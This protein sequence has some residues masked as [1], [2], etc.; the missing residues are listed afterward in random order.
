[1][2]DDAGNGS[3]YLR[4]LE[5]KRR[6]DLFYLGIADV[7]LSENR[8]NGPVDL[9]QGENASTALRFVGG[10]PAGVLRER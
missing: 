10:W 1:M 4:D 2:V 5:F 3:L 6:T 8:S 9:L 7:T